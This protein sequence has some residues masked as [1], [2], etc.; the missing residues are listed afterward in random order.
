MTAKLKEFEW[1][2]NAIQS[3]SKDQLDKDNVI[4]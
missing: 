4:S 2:D 3:L 1:T